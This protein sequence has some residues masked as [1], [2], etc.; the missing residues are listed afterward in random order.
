MKYYR[1]NTRII[2]F[3]NKKENK[4]STNFQLRIKQSESRLLGLYECIGFQKLNRY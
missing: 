3:C 1:W 4:L 2:I